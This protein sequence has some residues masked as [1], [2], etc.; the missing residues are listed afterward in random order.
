[1]LTFLKKQ[2]GFEI[3]IAN[4]GEECLDI[5]KLAPPDLILLDVKMPNMDGFEV[6]QTLKSQ[7]TTW[8][9]PVIF[10][11]SLSEINDKVKAFK[12]GADDY[13]T[14][15][16]QFEEMLARINVHL[17]LHILQQQLKAQNQVL[18]EEIQVRKE[19]QGTV[20]ETNQLLAKRTLE[21]QERT[22]EL[23]SVNQQL[24]Q[25]KKQLEQRTVALE[26]ANQEL[27]RLNALDGLTLIANRCCFDEY[28][29]KKWYELAQEQ[30]PLSLIFADVDF[31]KRYNDYYGHLVGD[32]CLQKMAQSLNKI[33]KRSSDLVARYGG[34]E[35]VVLL[36]NVKTEEV[37]QIAE[38]IQEMIKNLKIVHAKSPISDYVTL[39]M[40]IAN[41]IPNPNFSPEQ[42]IQMA[43]EA[44]YQAKHQG[45]NCIVVKK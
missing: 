38:N 24:K 8:D 33:V 7:E 28:I 19:I 34:E 41:L 26:N 18:Q 16:I 27:K 13:V 31:F 4:N 40:G 36:P 20:Q 35:F 25:L 12:M 37:I 17:N 23:E 21:L 3:L 30:Q 42:L 39:S 2:T 5:V 44:L 1:L 32:D 22:L 10:M 29:T 43:D 11:T 9:I 15:P 45:R 6:C 14:K